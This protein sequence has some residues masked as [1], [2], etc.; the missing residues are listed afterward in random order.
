MRV[1]LA[2]VS[3][4]HVSP[5]WHVPPDVQMLEILWQDCGKYR[6]PGL[7]SFAD[8]AKHSRHV[9][10][11]MP[12]R[13]SVVNM[14]TETLDYIRA[15]AVPGVNGLTDERP[16]AI[17]SD[18]HAF[19]SRL[20]HAKVYSFGDSFRYRRV[21]TG[22]ESTGRRSHACTSHG[23]ARAPATAM[24]DAAAEAETEENSNH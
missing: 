17:Q 20:A 15:K 5:F 9:N 6:L 1:F 16:T 10:F 14:T 8:V 2:C 13:V 3:L 19:Y 24:Y 21:G 22:R 4:W 23:P 7:F 12:H 11:D 18:L